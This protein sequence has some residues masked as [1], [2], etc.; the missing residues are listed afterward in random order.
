MLTNSPVNVGGAGGSVMISVAELQSDGNTVPLTVESGGAATATA[1]TFRS[2]AGD[3]TAVS[4]SEGG[5]MMVGESQLIKADGSADPFPCDGMLPD[6][7]GLRTFSRVGVKC[8]D[9]G[10]R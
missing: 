6:C 5:S 3:I 4:I 2:T 1:T 9:I 7:A 10:G 8:P